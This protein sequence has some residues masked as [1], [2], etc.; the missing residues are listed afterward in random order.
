MSGPEE[1]E[2]PIN[3]QDEGTNILPS[4]KTRGTLFCC[5]SC[6]I[7]FT[8][9]DDAYTTSDGD[10]QQVVRFVHRVRK[11]IQN[12][13]EK[14]GI[15]PGSLWQADKC[16]YLH[17]FLHQSMVFHM[18]LIRVDH[19]DR[20]NRT[21]RTGRTA[22]SLNLTDPTGSEEYV[23]KPFFP[24]S[25]LYA[26]TS[27]QAPS[28]AAASRKTQGLPGAGSS[29]RLVWSSSVV[30]ACNRLVVRCRFR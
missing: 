1:G 27:S 19:F 10:V 16:H 23:V 18:N 29:C 7:P 20:L 9:P 13:D 22:R 25:N 3:E 15:S 28:N 14:A 11:E 12:S 8:F 24:A 17:Q 4:S 21:F 30:D 2:E 5:L 26:A 6:G